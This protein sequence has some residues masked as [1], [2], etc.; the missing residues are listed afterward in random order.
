MPATPGAGELAELEQ[1]AVDAATEAG[2]FILEDRPAELGVAK[3]KSSATDVVTVMDQQAE[4]LLRRRITAARPHDAIVGEEAAAKDGS[5]GVTWLIDPIDGTVNYLYDI[6]AYC[7]S[8]AAVTGDASTAGAWRPVA[9]AVCN[10][11]T[12]EVFHARLGGGARLTGGRG[13]PPKGVPV[14]VS[15][16]TELGQALTGTGFGYLAEVRRRQ[17]AVAAALLPHVRDLRRAGSAALDLCA[18]AS[19]HLDA[20]FESGLNPWDL[21]AGWLIAT[22]AGALVT[23]LRSAGPAASMTVAA[24]PGVHAQ[25]VQRLE[26]LVPEA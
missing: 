20:Y 9:A 26:E 14:A 12:G 4:Q 24:G 22:E 25:L 15:G 21:A 18:V 17:G 6:P 11:N 16:V 3:T 13:T 10:P 23:G 7:V 5:S 1:L 2:R 19:G 8:V